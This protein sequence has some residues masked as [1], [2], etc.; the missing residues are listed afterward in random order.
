[1]NFF[2]K[3]IRVIIGFVVGVILASGVTVYAYSYIAKD[4]MYTKKDGS[5]ISV[6]QALNELYERENIKYTLKRVSLGETSGTNTTRYY[7]ATGIPNY[8]NLTVDNFSLSTTYIDSG[9]SAGTYCGT[10][11]KGCENAS[12][13]SQ[14]G[15]L[16]VSI[17]I[18]LQTNAYVNNIKIK[19]DVFYIEEI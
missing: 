15:I 19:C 8:Q 13:N 18:L 10:T 14:T 12:Y 7:D 2:R 17:D 11:Y 1:M 16:T 6:D 9:S 5:E 3:N 4:V